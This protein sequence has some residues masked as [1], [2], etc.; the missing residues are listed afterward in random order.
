MRSLFI[1]RLLPSAAAACVIF[2]VA[3]QW[4]FAASVQVFSTDFTALPAQVTGG[5]NTIED[6]QGFKGLGPAGNQFAGN[7]LHNS[8][9]GN[10][11]T[12]TTL[13]LTGLQTHTSVDINYLL[14]VIDSW[15]GQQA[16]D[17]F[18]VRVNGVS[19]FAKSFAIASGTTNY[20]P[21]L[22]GDIGGGAQERGFTMSGSTFFDEAFNMALEPAFHNIAHSASTLTVDFF[23][24]GAGWQGGT[25]ESWGIDNLNV[26][27]N[28]VPDG[29]PTGVPLPSAAWSG[30]VMMG[31]LATFKMVRTRAARAE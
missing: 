17:I 15:D 24:S 23:A 10:P 26:V 21:P 4:A 8:S 22:N 18:N 25:D 11:A 2:C 12:L 7:L 5:A 30:L 31:L 6:G 28:G 16:P 1:R 13:T 29:Q 20:T 19:V 3:Q 27:L 14:A 9:M